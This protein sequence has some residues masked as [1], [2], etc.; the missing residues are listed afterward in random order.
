MGGKFYAFASKELDP[1][2]GFG[3]I[4]DYFIPLKNNTNLRFYGS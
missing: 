2:Y 3:P 1:N 4:L